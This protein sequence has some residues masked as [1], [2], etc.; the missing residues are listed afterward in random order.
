MQVNP[1]RKIVIAPSVSEK[2]LKVYDAVSGTIVRS[3]DLAHI[4]H[5][6]MLLNQP[7]KVIQDS[8][9]LLRF[10]N[11]YDLV[12]KF[13]GSAEPFSNAMSDFLN[14]IGVTNSKTYTDKFNDV[15]TKEDRQKLVEEFFR[16]LFRESLGEEGQAQKRSGVVGI[17]RR[18]TKRKKQVSTACMLS[19]LCT[20]GLYLLQAFPS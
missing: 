3:I 12:L 18:A 13:G 6:D 20:V 5:C 4:K 10:A 14:H 15:F 11:L 8:K 9:I 19:A 16:L 17:R 1:P 7:G 2:K